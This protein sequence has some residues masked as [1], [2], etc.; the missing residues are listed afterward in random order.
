MSLFS[1]TTS[2]TF[3]TRQGKVDVEQKI[4]HYKTVRGGGPRMGSNEWYEWKEKRDSAPTNAFDEFIAQ[5]AAD[6]WRVVALTLDAE[7][8]TP[9]FL[10]VL[11]RVAP[12]P[13]DEDDAAD[14]YD[15][16][17]IAAERLRA[18]EDEDISLDDFAAE[19]GI[20]ID[21][22]RAQIEGVAA[23]VASSIK[24]FFNSIPDYLEEPEKK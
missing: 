3:T 2:D 19:L 9:A 20:D 5:Y 13:T 17:Q 12:A 7:S 6:G 11:E 15:A 16:A 14:D 18:S 1:T 23:G 22:I 4:V 21:H 8:W 24:T 10:I